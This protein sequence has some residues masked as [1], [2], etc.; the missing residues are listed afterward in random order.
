VVVLVEEL[1]TRFI[2]QHKKELENR[3]MLEELVLTVVQ[4]Q[5]EAVL[6]ETVETQDQT[7]ARAVLVD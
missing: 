1:V 7:L 4:A 5:V 2:K 6:A 3:A